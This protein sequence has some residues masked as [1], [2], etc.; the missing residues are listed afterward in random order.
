MGGDLS[1]RTQEFSKSAEY[2]LIAGGS[3]EKCMLLLSEFGIP[4]SLI[5]FRPLSNTCV[6]IPLLGISE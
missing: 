6:S 5:L 3:S 2:A 1:L 4:K